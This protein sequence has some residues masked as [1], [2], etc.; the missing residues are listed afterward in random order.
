WQVSPAYMRD[1]AGCTQLFDI[2]FAPETVDAEKVCWRLMPAGTNPE[3]PW[4]LDL[5]ALLGGDNRVA[6]LRSRVWSGETRTLVLEL[7]SDDGV[8]VWL[9]GKIV[10]SNNT[11]RAIQPAQ[12]KV[13]LTL[14]EGWNTLML[15]ITQ[16]VMGWGA[17]ARF[18]GPGG[19][20]IEGLRFQTQ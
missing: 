8:K 11:M 19:S 10:H 2:V 7:G 14:Q 16:N 17:C 4:L 18:T 12:E 3:Q 5:L 13:T 1:G 20:S 9:N 6:Y 15:K